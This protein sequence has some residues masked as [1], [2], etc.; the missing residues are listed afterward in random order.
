MKLLDFLQHF[1]QPDPMVS[2]LAH[3]FYRVD[4]QGP[5]CENGYLDICA[6]TIKSSEILPSEYYATKRRIAYRVSK[7]PDRILCFGD[8]GSFSL[9]VYFKKEVT[10]LLPLLIIFL[11]CSNVNK[12]DKNRVKLN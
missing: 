6:Q 4:S 2:N 8:A 5:F 11:H 10:V 9:S 7:E 3:V 1:D 12:L